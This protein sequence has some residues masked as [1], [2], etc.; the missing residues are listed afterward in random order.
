[1]V[2][3]YFLE[4]LDETEELETPPLQSGTRRQTTTL[5][6]TSVIIRPLNLIAV[7]ACRV[8]AVRNPSSSTTLTRTSVI[9]AR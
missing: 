5:T 9:Y 7:T 6:R 2:I 1:M 4:A 3:E 8:A